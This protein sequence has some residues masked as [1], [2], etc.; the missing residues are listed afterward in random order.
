MNN[1]K[2]SIIVPS[3][4]TENWATIFNSVKNNIGNYPFEV[5]FIGPNINLSDELVQYKN[6]KCIRDFGCPS[7]SMQIGALF[8]EGKYL[9]WIC[10]DGIFVDGAIGR[11]IER[12]ENKNNPKFWYNWIYTEGDEYL[13]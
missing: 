9:S 13:T 7:R 12:L 8:A 10:D 11:I 1:I 6:I 4:R 2:L 5:I 3:I